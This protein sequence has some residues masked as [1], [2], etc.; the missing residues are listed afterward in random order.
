MKNVVPYAPYVPV[1][2]LPGQYI[3]PIEVADYVI[4]ENRNYGPDNLTP[5]NHIMF[6]FKA[7]K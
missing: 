7:K 2:Y 5:Q 3:S 4:S 1:F 6:L